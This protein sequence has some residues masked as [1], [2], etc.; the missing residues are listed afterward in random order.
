MWRETSTLEKRVVSV[1]LLVGL[2]LGYTKGEYGE[3]SQPSCSWHMLDL[4]FRGIYQKRDG[5]T[6]LVNAPIAQM[7]QDER[8]FSKATK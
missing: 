1:L 2:E 4:M 5:R 6:S 7:I 3:G 8:F